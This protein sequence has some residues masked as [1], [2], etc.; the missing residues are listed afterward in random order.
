VCVLMNRDIILQGT[1][2]EGLF[3]IRTAESTITTS[4]RWCSSTRTGT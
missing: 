2:T 3:G 4:V 1:I